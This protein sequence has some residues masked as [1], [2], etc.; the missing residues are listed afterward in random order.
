MT[1]SIQLTP[2]L[3]EHPD[4]SGRVRGVEDLL[5]ERLQRQ[6]RTASALWDVQEREGR[7]VLTLALSDPWG[8]AASDFTPEEIA[9]TSAMQRRLDSLLGE[10]VDS[11]RNER[12]EIRDAYVTTEQLEAFRRSLGNIPDI[13]RKGLKLHNQLRLLPERLDRFLLTDFAVEVDAPAA[14]QVKQVIRD[15]GFTLRDDPLLRKP[16]VV[17][18]VKHL[19]Q[20]HLHDGQPVPRHAIW[21]N[22]HDPVDLHLLEIAD[23]VPSLDDGSLEGVGFTAGASLPGARS[24]VLYLTSPDDLRRTVQ[25]HPYHPAIR[26]LRANEVYFVYPDDEGMSFRAAFPE[27]SGSGP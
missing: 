27:F 22:L 8:Y 25:V 21:F 26:A 6:S 18:A 1:V 13:S 4:F 7:P 17:E 20:A 12:I 19:V 16:G 24:I 14:D 23:G 2:A 9:P 3:E 10:L 15:C 11:A 5:R